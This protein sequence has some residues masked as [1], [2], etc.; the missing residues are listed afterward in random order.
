MVSAGSAERSVCHT[1]ACGI[2]SHAPH[3]LRAPRGRLV[4]GE[5]GGEGPHRG[6]GVG[7]NGHGRRVHRGELGRVDI[8]ADD[9]ARYLEFRQK[10]IAGCDF[11]AHQQHHISSGQCLL[12]RSLQDRA[13]EG[14]GMGVRKDPL[15]GVR[16]QN[17]RADALGDVRQCRA[18]A[19]R[20]TTDKDQ[21]AP[22][23][24]EAPRGLIDH[25]WIGHRQR[26][27]ATRLP[28]GLDG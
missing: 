5:G 26:W 18:R 12:T 14:Q 21:R 20:A 25:R 9:V 17:G 11:R 3:A 6:T 8:D 28:G 13:A 23:L 4:M 16:S 10:V 7:L 19:S 15:A 1:R 24:R 2:S 27:S 22:G